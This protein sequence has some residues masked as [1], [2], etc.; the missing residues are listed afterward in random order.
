[1]I[2]PPSTKGI[3]KRAIRC[4]PVPKMRDWRSL[5]ND[6]LTLAEKVM[7]FGEL[8]L[9]IP[10]GKDAG[11]PLVLDEF[12]QAFIY[13]VFDNPHGTRVAIL[14]LARKNGK[15]ALLALILLAYLVGPLAKLNSQIASGAMSR[16][17]AA[18]IFSLACKMVQFSP[19]I[20]DLI[21]VVPSGKRLIGL[22]ANTEYKALA[23][24]GK[25]THGLSLRVCI[26]DEAGQIVG[27]RSE[28]VEAMTTS[29]GAH[30]DAITIYISTQ[31]STDGDML[32]I[33]IDDAINSQDPRTV[34]HLYEAK[35]D[36]DILD[37]KEWYYANPGLGIFRSYD[38]LKE[39]LMRASRMPSAESGAR[40]L[41]LN[42]R[43]STVTPFISQSVWESNAET[44]DPLDGQ[45]V[46]IGLDL[47]SRTD[48]TAAVV[49]FES[50]GYHHV[51]PFFWLPEINLRDRAKQD[52]VPY[53]VWAQQGYLKTCP[54]ATVDYEVVI[55]DLIEELGSC[56]VEAVPFDRWKIDIFKK[57][58][59]TMGIEWPMVE[60]GQGFKDMSPAL[61]ALEAALL[62][63]KI[64]HGKH[65]V[66]TMCAANAIATKDPAGNR[67]LDKSKATGRIDGLVALA[68]TMRHIEAE[69]VMDIDSFLAEP[70]IL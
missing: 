7:R 24:E 13:A 48:L 10:E 6:Q 61:E 38:D 42:Q 19:K 35:K 51:H 27:P 30:E 8:Y 2:K 14:S 43:V 49:V 70:L 32:S 22:R 33:L 21:R 17:Q 15:T 60:H 54:G 56:H 62:N 64:K 20:K 36:A 1:M 9:C 69:E 55:R 58:L 28:F 44:P 25:T 65:P 37:E 45:S 63:G 50:E 57:E 59:D 47:S 29:Q 23:A 31:A 18:I 26:I 4:G 46:I 53:D 68:M 11:K 34:C 41:L 12:Q 3:I 16:D 39:N 52:R 40:N 5:P 66:L 67:K